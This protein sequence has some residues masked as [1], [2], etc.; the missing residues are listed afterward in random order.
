LYN[1][2]YIKSPETLNL[3]YKMFDISRKVLT[4][5]YHNENQKIN[6]PHLIQFLAQDGFVFV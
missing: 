1:S 5:N 4:Y 2:D 6:K 3:T